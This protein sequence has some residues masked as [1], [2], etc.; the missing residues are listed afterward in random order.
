MPLVLLATMYAAF[1]GLTGAY[2][3]PL[4]YLLAFGVY[5]IGWCPVFPAAILG[6]P[7][8]VLE[9]FREAQPRFGRPAWKS[10][11]LLLWP[12]VFPL[13]FALIPKLA[14]A[15]LAILG[16]SGLLGLV[17]GIT[18]EILWRGIF[19]RLFPGRI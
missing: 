15:N 6:G 9:L 16:G 4:G 8:K 7:H 1:R 13:F 18:E 19:I 10:L 17:I 12:L 14:Q 11:S 5:W 2:G 3:Y